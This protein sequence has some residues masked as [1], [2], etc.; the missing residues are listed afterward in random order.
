MGAVRQA[1]AAGE[2]P[3]R[4]AAEADEAAQ[5]GRRGG[6]PGGQLPPEVSAHVLLLPRGATEGP[7]RVSQVR[8]FDPS[9]GHSAAD[10]LTVNTPLLVSL[11]CIYDLVLKVCNSSRLYGLPEELENAL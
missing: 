5:G 10:A 8:D 6:E 4:S 2:L 1:D 3:L 11:T 9:S 7:R